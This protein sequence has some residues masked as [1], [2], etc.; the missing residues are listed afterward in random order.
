MACAHALIFACGVAWLATM[1]GWE[2][3]FAVGVTPFIAATII[4]TILAAASLP[5]AWEFARRKR[6]GL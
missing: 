5:V 1:M 6:T 3:A 4:K 2:R